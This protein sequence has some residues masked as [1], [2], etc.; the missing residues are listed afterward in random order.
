MR[1]HL[2]PPTDRPAYRPGRLGRRFAK[3]EGGS[4]DSGTPGERTSLAGPDAHPPKSRCDPPSDFTIE[5]ASW[6][7]ASN[8]ILSR[9]EL[10]ESVSA[11]VISVAAASEPRGSCVGNVSREQSREKCSEVGRSHSDR[12]DDPDVRQLAALAK[13]IHGRRAD[14]EL[15]GHLP[16]REQPVATTVEAPPGRSGWGWSGPA[17]RVPML[18]QPGWTSVGCA[19]ARGHAL[20]DSGSNRVTKSLGFLATGWDGWTEGGSVS[21]IISDGCEGFTLPGVPSS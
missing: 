21:A 1:S 7:V 20:R 3:R 8:Q 6:A 13:P 14:A 5:K 15:L 10:V 12:F 11:S 17:R 18:S 19:R 2:A 4:R 16:H 9:E